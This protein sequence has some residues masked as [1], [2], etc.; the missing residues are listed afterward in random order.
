MVVVTDGEGLV[1]EF[2][3]GL[4]IVEKLFMCKKVV[5]AVI[6]GASRGHLIPWSCHYWLLRATDRWV[7]KFKSMA[8]VVLNSLPLSYLPSSPSVGS[9]SSLKGGKKFQCVRL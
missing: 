5:S 8:K 7:L 1:S 2:F 6:S 3:K 4:V 9:N